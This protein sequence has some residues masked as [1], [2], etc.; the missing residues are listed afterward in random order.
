MDIYL[1]F[2]IEVQ[3]VMKFRVYLSKKRLFRHWA[4]HEAR[5]NLLSISVTLSFIKRL[6]NAYH[7]IDTVKVTCGP[8]INGT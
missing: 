1:S 7:V 4:L 5:A 3:Y 8:K 6:L 2:S